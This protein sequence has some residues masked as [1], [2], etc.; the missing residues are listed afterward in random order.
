MNTCTR[1]HSS[2]LSLSLSLPLPLP[3]PPPPPPPPLPSPPP[4]PLLFYPFRS[5]SI[6]ISLSLCLSLSPSLLHHCFVT[7]AIFLTLYSCSYSICPGR[8]ATRCGFQV[9]IDVCKT[10]TAWLNTC[11][12][13]SLFAYPLVWFM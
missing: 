8:A 6:C 3:P 9:P 5:M 7:D 11:N 10:A 1:T 2:S 4:P 12:A 13:R